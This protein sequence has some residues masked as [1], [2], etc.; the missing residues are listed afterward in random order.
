MENDRA[1]GGFSASGVLVPM[2]A[3]GAA[4]AA[5]IV[6]GPAT[7]GQIQ[8]IAFA[9]AACAVGIVTAWAVKIRRVTTPAARVTSSLAAAAMRIFPA[10][11]ALGW[12]QSSGDG[13][14]SS[15]ASKYLV[16]FY[17]AGLAA[18][19]VQAASK[20]RRGPRDS[21]RDEAI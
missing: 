15:G 18:E 17:L 1:D 8:A 6:I 3:L 14:R 4:I 5:V 11:A 2:G 13:L 7:A 20:G 12:L 10:L 9:A 21:P 19:V 16:L